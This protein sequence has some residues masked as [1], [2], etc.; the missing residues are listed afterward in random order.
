M[1][2]SAPVRPSARA[3][4]AASSAVRSSSAV[5]TAP[6]HDATRRPSPKN[7]KAATP[8]PEAAAS[9]SV[10]AS[11]AT[12][13]RPCSE[14]LHACD[15]A[16]AARLPLVSP[17]LVP[18]AAPQKKTAR[19]TT[20]GTRA[21]VVGSLLGKAMGDDK[22]TLSSFCRWLAKE[23]KASDEEVVISFILLDR[24]LAKRDE[25]S[26][27]LDKG[28]WGK[29][30]L[31]ACVLLLAMKVRRDGALV[32]NAQMAATLSIPLKQFNA[33]ERFVLI[34]LDFDLFVPRAD[35]DQ[36]CALLKPA[37]AAAVASAAAAP[38]P[39]PA[40]PKSIV[41]LKSPRHLAVPPPHHPRKRPH[42]ETADFALPAA[43]AAATEPHRPRPRVR[44][45]A[46][47]HG[48]GAAG[49][50]GASAKA[51]PVRRKVEAEGAAAAE[52]AAAAT[53]GTAEAAARSRSRGRGGFAQGTQRTQ[54]SS[55]EACGAKRRRVFAPCNG[56]ALVV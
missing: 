53:G 33:W 42:A 24:V 41:L 10:S 14:E 17:A 15:A 34:T 1:C 29:E 13:P 32:G 50:A 40:T 16:A 30:R 55:Q 44:M 46:A 9:A 49:A 35:F 23:V 36:Y 47:A 52:A 54:C 5:A 48:S 22:G 6:S 19:S 18:A 51:L 12:A 7:K 45:C 31:M 38:A 25:V 8:R 2:N 21:A 39:A 43:A 11:T 37:A 3:V 26:Q 56:S 4:A 27:A 28:T 20:P